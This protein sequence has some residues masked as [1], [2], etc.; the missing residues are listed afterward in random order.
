[1]AAP[2]LLDAIRQ[3]L[4]GEAVDVAK[5]K[6]P[7]KSFTENYVRPAGNA[8]IDALIP[9]AQAAEPQQSPA[10][11][12]EPY[13]PNVE[14]PYQAMFGFKREELVN[15]P[16]YNQAQAAQYGDPAMPADPLQDVAPAAQPQPADT[17]AVLPNPNKPTI[18]LSIDDFDIDPEKVAQF[19]I[20]EKQVNEGLQNFKAVT[21]GM[22]LQSAIDKKEADGEDATPEKTMLERISEGVKSFMGSEERML[23]AAMAFNTL[24][25]DPD[26]ALGQM[27]GKRLETIREEKK[28]QAMLPYIQKNYPQFAPLVAAGVMTAKEIMTL[29]TKNPTQLQQYLEM[30]KT[31]EGLKQLEQLK[32]IGAIGS[33][34]NINVDTK[35]A[36]KYNEKFAE[37]L[38]KLQ[39][40]IRGRGQASADLLD[41]LNRFAAAAAGMP[42]GQGQVWKKDLM[43]LAQGFGF[44]VNEAELAQAQSVDAAAALMV[45]QELRKNKGPQTDFDAEFTKTFVPS[46]K[47]LPETNKQIQRYMKSVNRLQLIKSSYMDNGL[48]GTDYESDNKLMTGVKNMQYQIPAV[49]PSTATAGGYIMFDDFYNAYSA[50]YPQADQKTIMRDW[51]RKIR[52]PVPEYLK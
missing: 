44:D 28:S 4:L 14:D 51:M 42:T 35:G 11:V 30:L 49:A 18:D 27:I 6:E 47:N 16:A 24:R 38:V 45:A 48:T 31:P 12:T 5:E 8:I 40:D 26:D 25:Y 36:G 39:D 7:I 1:M 13:N 22:E 34:T 29:A 3:Y 52:K 20:G 32:K 9:S 19:G 17:R 50:K 2:L 21:H 46:L 15:S 10:S 43:T 33:S 41:N 23:G 37:S